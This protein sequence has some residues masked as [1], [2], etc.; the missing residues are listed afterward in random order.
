MYKCISIRG[1][2]EHNLKNV[3]IDIP[4]NC[5]VV[6]TGV[7]GSGKSSLAFDTLYAEGQRR[8]VESLS[9]YARQ[10][11]EMN[12]KPDVDSI[13]GLSPAIAIDQ[14][15]VSKNPR[16]TVA[17]ITEIY[18]YL[19][20]LF[21]RIGIPYSPVTGLPIKKQSAMQMVDVLM[22][23]PKKTSIIL[24]APIVCGQKGEYKKD[25]LRYRRLSYEKV[26]IDGIYY[27]FDELPVI[28]KNKRHNI[29][30]VIDQIKIENDS[31]EKLLSSVEDVLRISKGELCIEI[32]SLPKGSP[33][34]NKTEGEIMVFSEHFSCPLSG[35]VL[36]KIEPRIFSFNSP[37]GACPKCNGLGKEM[38]FDKKLL[39]PDPSLSLSEGAITVWQNQNS[40]Y[41]NTQYKFRENLLEALS[42]HYRFSLEE[43]FEDLQKHIQ[44][45]ILHG[46]GGEIIKISYQEGYKTS[47]V[48]KAYKGIIPLLE[49]QLQKT[50]SNRIV[51]ELSRYQV[52][53][54]C[55]ECSGY[56]IK[57][58]SLCVRVGK[59]HIGEVSEFTIDKAYDWSKNLEKT[60]DPIR[61]KIARS[62]LKEIER[63]LKFLIDVGVNYLTLNRMSSA[64]SGG[65]SQRIRLASQIG[66]NL[67]GIL[68]VLDEPS[69]GLH[70]SDNNK[71][72]NTLKK[73]RDLGN[74]IIVV[75]HDEDTM[76]K[77]DHLID[78]GKYAGISGGRVI[79]QGTP[80]EVSK[81]EESITGKYL[82]E[83]Y[84][85][86]VSKERRKYSRVITIKNVT[87]NNLKNV[88]V[89]IPIMNFVAVTGVSGS[90]KSSLIL[91][92]LYGVV[93][94]KLHNSNKNCGKYTSIHGL[95]NIDKIIEIDQ[96][97]IGRTPRSNP[98]TY[99]GVFAP[100]RDWYT[101]LK[102]SKLRGY[103]PGRFS[104]NVKGGRCEVCEGDGSLRV[105]MHFLSNVYIKCNE[106]GGKR[107]N[108]ETLQIKYNGKSIS[109]VL[110]VTVDE[111]IK[112]FNDLP[113][114][115]DKLKA[116][117]AVGLGYINIGQSA[118][119]L[120]GGEAQRIKLAKE[121]SKRSTGRTL[122][123]LD[124]PTTGLHSHD[125]Q[126][127]LKVL[128]KL[129]D[130][131]NTVIVIEHNLD[132]IKTADYVID[133]G[134]QGGTKGGK[135][136]AKGTPE[137]VSKAPNSI[138]GQYLAAKL[139]MTS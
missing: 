133:I 136:V 76:R 1:A 40:K 17:T 93:M 139:A 96:Q 60:L 102:E 118:I 82:S 38:C 49:A 8:Y 71:L 5:L 48:N 56:R 138:T 116:L 123:I 65:E 39:I 9:S 135:I 106:C 43:P 33:K 52:Q 32:E 11:L 77:A 119:T 51:E 15:T 89:D 62:I 47:T 6:I 29:E 69:I 16:S 124:E 125:I 61:A 130:M 70:Q 75:E 88:S 122:Y 57:K 7:S 115:N 14:R 10:F 28:D 137:E 54:D 110:E 12:N 99:T 92:T 73:L 26:K 18:D 109:D 20:V 27:G 126:N 117:Q 129:V 81:N 113:L 2:R 37:Y 45:I 83:K 46:S 50:G 107:Y 132:V 24:L 59:L 55:S 63:R 97:P 31:R 131:G 114:I 111:G 58:D 34:V 35:L 134:P 87:T 4:K 91:Q 103:L 94:K 19:R 53:V 30:L 78:I 23:L 112:F 22:E 80:E 72:I 86:P 74:S 105:E 101:R 108:K 68:Y 66:S 25:L 3:N 120:S 13:E 64:L 85:I 121:L 79:A 98:A 21:A 84:F 127:L 128:H 104:F 41:S 42:K 36:S 95:E 44:N 90:G 67:T 100:I